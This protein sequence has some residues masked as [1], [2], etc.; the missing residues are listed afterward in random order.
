MDQAD[1]GPLRLGTRASALARWQADW[2]AER[3]RKQGHDVEIVLIQSQGDAQQTGPIAL[4]GAQGVF[5]KEL[6]HA[7]LEGQIDLAVHSMKD[8]P[9]VQP[10]GLVVAAVTERADVHDALVC[11]AATSLAELPNGAVVGTGSARRRAQ[12]LAG[13]PDLQIR[14][15][16]GNV[17]TRLRKLDEG[18]Y[19]AIVLAA[20]G[21]RRLELQ[22]RITQLLPPDVMLPAPAQGALAIECRQEDS[23][24]VAA[25]VALDHAPTRAAVTAERAAL[26][27]LEGG[28]LAAMGALADC[29]GESLKLSAVVLS[30]DGQRRL[31]AQGEG[32]PDTAQAIGEQVAS[33]LLEAGAAELL[34]DR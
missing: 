18:Q 11:T 7:L 15:L 6:Q 27:K 23:R 20:A 17:D 10:D 31:F 30:V 8:L 25:L 16:R 33:K 4:L 3:L 9:T 13:R 34:R 1:R 21:L 29:A 5:T 12:L 14:D 32:P 28:C 22:H 19:D 24:T 2:T 26:R